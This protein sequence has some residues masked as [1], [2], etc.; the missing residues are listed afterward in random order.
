[1]TSSDDETVLPM[2]SED[3][4]EPLSGTT[5]SQTKVKQK[6]IVKQKKEK[7]TDDLLTS[8]ERSTAKTK[9]KT[10]KKKKKTKKE[11]KE[12][13]KKE[14][15]SNASDHIDDPAE[16]VLSSEKTTRIGPSGRDGKI[17]GRDT[18]GGPGR[19]TRSM[20]QPANGH[21]PPKPPK[22]SILKNGSIHHQQRRIP[23]KHVS[24]L[25]RINA[26]GS[27]SVF[28]QT[29]LHLTST[30]SSDFESSDDEYYFDDNDEESCIPT[31]NRT[32]S[33]F[34]RGLGKS[35]GHSSMGS[36]SSSGSGFGGLSKL[37][38]SVM[39]FGNEIQGSALPKYSNSSRSSSVLTDDLEQ[40]H[41]EPKWKSFLRYARILAP[42]PN[43]KPMKRNIRIMTWATLLCDFLAALVSITTYDGVTECC[44]RPILSIA[45]PKV[46]WD[47]AI[48]IT[49]YVYMV[50]I[51]AEILPVVREKLPLNLLNPFVGF[52][53]TFAVFFDDRKPEAVAMWT[54]E[55]SAVACEVAVYRLNLRFYRERHERC[56]KI[57]QDLKDMK[58][59][60]RKVKLQRRQAA[61]G[62]YYS[63]ETSS[64]D[65][66]FESGRS[67]RKTKVSDLSTRRELKLMRERRLLRQ[68]HSEEKQS[69]RYHFMGVLFNCGLV[70]ISLLLILCIGRSKG[71]CIKDM[72]VPS[73]FK[74]NQLDMC[75]DIRKILD[76]CQGSS[77]VCEICRD[78]GTSQCYYPYY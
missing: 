6:A 28:D 11:K 3:E 53:I 24:H 61:S 65:D 68:S 38:K 67:K 71:L 16:R 26:D 17:P 62:G 22:A 10:K 75:Y 70:T 19:G 21:M 59:E 66:T 13:T 12:A 14:S 20:S 9:K 64:S 4:D 1:M 56:Q 43:E 29:P 74:K 35:S 32:P 41:D 63:D 47:K 45:T 40:F 30:S 78:D 52:L 72:E 46:D 76:D 57:D 34:D 7:T 5:V 27:V 25:T 33:T 51:F 18:P 44:G 42:T 60:R 23:P 77:G 2:T 69:L 54:I 73:L 39:A 50:M 37:G 55:G 31:I 8:S 49:T 36:H 48:R 58:R 15:L